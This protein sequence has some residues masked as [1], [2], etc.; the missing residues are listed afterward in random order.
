MGGATGQGGNDA[1]GI[2]IGKIDN[3]V[4]PGYFADP[5]VAMFGDKLFIYP[6]TDG[7]T[8]WMG[9]VFH[10]FSSS[11]L[12]TWRDEGIILDL[13]N[14]SWGKQ[15][16]WAPGITVKNGT[17]Y[18]YFC[19]NQE[20]GVATA[21]SPTGPFKDVLDKPLVS[22]KQFGVASIDPYVFDDDDGRSYLFFG[23]GSSA[24][25]V[26][27]GADMVSLK[28]TPQTITLSGFR[29]GSVVF[30]RNGTYYFMYS[31]SGTDK[32]DYRVAYGTSKSVLGPYTVSANSTI[33]QSSANLGIQSTGH[34]SVL[35]LPNGDYYI[36]YHRWAI[37]NGDGYHREV[38][39]DKMKFNSDGSIAPVALTL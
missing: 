39:I 16:A 13:K 35:A 33:L 23:S 18:F 36:V 1:G 30:K 4:I 25:G 20:I 26:E 9:T 3:P 32:P 2:I 28:G 19:D 17:Y 8:N 5:Q 34:N 15:Q 29:E 10:A 11:D 37:P 14:V 12:A 24:R 38:C 27:L 21:K 7:V 31:I 6:T 22:A